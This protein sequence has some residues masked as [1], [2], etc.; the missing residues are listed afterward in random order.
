MHAPL[1]CIILSPSTNSDS[2][3][4]LQALSE[5]L[6]Q[7]LR[8][9]IRRPRFL[10]GVNSPRE[11]DF[12]PLQPLLQIYLSGNS[13][14]SLPC[15]LFS[16]DN[17]TVL[18]LRNNNL[19]VLSP[20]ISNLRNL[21]ELNIAGNGLR[22][23]PWEFLDLVRGENLQSLTALPNPLLRPFTFD[24]FLMDEF[25]MPGQWEQPRTKAH[26]DAIVQ[27]LEEK[28]ADYHAD[29]AA[30]TAT[31][32]QI[33]LMLEL[34]KGYA[35]A[36]RAAVEGLLKKGF[37]V[38]DD[39]IKTLDDM[40]ARFSEVE[41]PALDLS[42]TP[43]FVAS[44]AVTRF[45][46]DGS[47]PQGVR[48]NSPPSQLPPVTE[49]L[50]AIPGGAPTSSRGTKVPSLFEL[51]ARSASKVTELPLLHTLLPEDAPR[52]VTEALQTACRA[53]EEGGRLCS[54]CGGDYIMPRT[55]W[56]EYWHLPPKFGQRSSR[57]EM[58]WPFLRRGCSLAC[59]PGG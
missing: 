51:A 1:F 25:P 2:D 17:L 19:G 36:C 37:L 21:V 32:E 38:L 8:S 24:G 48:Q 57:E 39:D 14:S 45:D 42:P 31:L 34:C 50:P 41:T 47:L 56:I 15:E 52:P 30:P 13:L 11:T 4:N 40:W 44:T 28:L 59:V 6:L 46:G 53:R 35:K 3:L 23:L 7:P 12:H 5:G 16:L 9:V 49:T 20:H 33:A 54:V 29:P 26:L 43:I 55:E 58:F 22:Y 10:D 18:S 27:K